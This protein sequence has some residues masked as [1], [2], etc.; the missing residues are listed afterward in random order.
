MN[1][2]YITYSW[3]IQLY[4]KLAKPINISGFDGVI[5]RLTAIPFA[6]G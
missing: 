5:I 2:L 1:L 4:L 6:M 3:G